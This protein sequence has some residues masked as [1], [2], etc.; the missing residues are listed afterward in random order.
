MKPPYEIARSAADYSGMRLGVQRFTSS[1]VLSP[2]FARSRVST[3]E[4]AGREDDVL[5]D[6][7]SHGV[8][9]VVDPWTV[10]LVVLGADNT[11]E[12]KF[13]VKNNS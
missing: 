10:R 4:A 12:G 11:D 7:S 3:A 1:L 6:R 9:T 2:H 5:P 8:D 13:S